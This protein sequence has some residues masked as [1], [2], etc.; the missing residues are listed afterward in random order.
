MNVDADACLA[1]DEV[2][3]LAAS[4]VLVTRGC[5]YV[6]DIAAIVRVVLGLAAVAVAFGDG[7]AAVSIAVHGMAVSGHQWTR[8]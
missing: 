4:I 3:V 7:I 1:M 6:S 2:R 5:V 8:H